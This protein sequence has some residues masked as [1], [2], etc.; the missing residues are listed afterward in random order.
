M[1]VVKSKHKHMMQDVDFF[2]P[3]YQFTNLHDKKHTQIKN[4]LAGTFKCY[5]SCASAFLLVFRPVSPNQKPKERQ[6][7]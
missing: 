5:E 7:E 6:V 4:R 3:S 2:S 1:T